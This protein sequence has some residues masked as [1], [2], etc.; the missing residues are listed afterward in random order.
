MIVYADTS[1]L[2]SLYVPD[3]NASAAL[4][5]MRRLNS[6]L[7]STDFGEFEFVNSLNLSVF[8]GQM[9]PTDEQR[10][11]DLLANDVRTGLIQ[12]A[13]ITSAIFD[14]AR[15]LARAQTRALGTRSLD[16]LHVASALAL[17]ASTFLTFDVRQRKLALAAK[18][19]VP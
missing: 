11:L 7:I 1:F 19:R 3:V 16:V 12:I 10:V 2:F 14:R 17:K 8:R 13:P 6:R 18:L 4:A 9:Q 15:Q 5:T